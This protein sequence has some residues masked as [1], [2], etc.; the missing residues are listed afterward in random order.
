MQD[1]LFDEARHTIARGSKSF[2]AAARLFRPEMRRDVML[3][4][5]W[6][7]HCDDVTDGQALG[8]GALAT[9]D[10]GV[11]ARLQTESRAAAAGRPG[12]EL[13]YR[14]L[15]EVCRR[16]PLTDWMIDDH[17][18]GFELDVAGWQPE[19]LDDSLRYSYHVA[20][21]VGIMMARIM[22]VNDSEVLARACDLGI[23][24]QLTNIAR[25]V[26]EDARGGRCYLPA[27]WLREAGLQL[28]DLGHP[29]RQGRSFT[30]VERLLH[31]AEPYYDSARIGVSY[32]PPRAAWAIATALSVYRDIGR[33]LLRRGPQALMLRSSTGRSRKLLRVVAASPALWRGN[34]RDH[35]SRDP[36]LWTAPSLQQNFP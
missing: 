12:P 27:A 28:Q 36:A 5:S 17:L 19:T 20:G 16:H 21:V 23:A 35:G 13:P 10:R 2:A 30:L 22:N 32:L 11:L 4:Y 33:R 3:L 8:H 6:C 9:A 34:Q 15:T 25:D 18:Q 7:R 29:D 1:A 14:A 24:F 26:V 31:T